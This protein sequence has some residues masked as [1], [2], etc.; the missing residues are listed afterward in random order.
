MKRN[1]F[2]LILGAAILMASC[3]PKVKVVKNPMIGM[4]NTET[5]DIT[6]VE[7]T[8]SATYVNVEAYFQPKYW[9]KFT[10]DTYLQVDGKK[11][12]ITTT[13][14]CELDKQ[15]WMPESGRASFRF[16]FPPI[17]KRAESMDFIEGEGEG[18]FKLYDIDLTG[19]RSYEDYLK[20]H[21]DIPKELIKINEMATM[22]KPIFDVGKTTVTVHL[23]NYKEGFY[24][25]EFTLVNN[26]SYGGQEEINAHVDQK[27]GTITFEFTQYGTS[28]G[29]IGEPNSH[30]VMVNN[31]L[32]APNEKIEIYVDLKVT[33]QRIVA[34]REKRKDFYGFKS[35][36]D[37]IYK[38]YCAVLSSMS[39]RL[40]EQ[41]FRNNEIMLQIHNS[42]F[43]DYKWSAEE[44]QK[45]VKEKYLN[46][47]K[48]IENIPNALPL[49]KAYFKRQADLDYCIAIIQHDILMRRNYLYVNKVNTNQPIDYEF[50]TLSEEQM[51]DM[52]SLL[53]YNESYELTLF[54]IMDYRI[55]EYLNAPKNSMLYNRFTYSDYIELCTDNKM[56]EKR[57]EHL[58][59]FHGHDFI[60]K[61]A[62]VR[63]A[64]VQAELAKVDGKAKIE[65]TPDVADDKLFDAIIAPHKG[66]VICIDFWNT[67]CSPCRYAHKEIAKLKDGKL[68]SKDIIWIYIANDSSPIVAYKAAIPEIRGLHYRLDKNH[69]E[70]LTD[71]F[72]INSIP[73][74]VVVDKNG[75]YSL[76]NDFQDTNRMGNE[77][78]KMV[79]K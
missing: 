40:S 47:I 76:R 54:D 58:E 35:Y 28:E 65:P 32:I 64:E 33:G 12:V 77:L 23:L 13:E 4:S 17:P 16:T 21:P 67:W 42:R 34:R 70:A 18:A 78:L 14:G 63:H 73:S 5:L 55:A 43:A 26:V 20:P 3:S 7:I 44:Y 10:S 29:W 24:D 74:Y 71:K 38:D 30:R 48:N 49:D 51:R 62:K 68:K 56:T 61:A 37:G 39:D 2:L 25:K 31:L 11:Y 79:E 1:L 6:R 8:D 9:I 15:F 45:N 36:I 75:K 69:W 72:K 59:K 19:K 53:Q 66:K 50:A 52:S 22:P 27:K 60:L 46:I 41:Y 57:W